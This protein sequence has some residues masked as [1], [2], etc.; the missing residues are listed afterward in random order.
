MNRLPVDH[1]ATNL[2]QKHFNVSAIPL[3]QFKEG[4]I[5]VALGGR[6]GY[7]SA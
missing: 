4:R 2:L 1:Y 3:T 6:P 5:C 7:W